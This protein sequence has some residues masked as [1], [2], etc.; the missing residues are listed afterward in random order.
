VAI[1]VKSILFCKLT[2]YESWSQIVMMFKMNILETLSSIC[3]IVPWQ[4]NFV[5]CVMMGAKSVSK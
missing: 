5:I 4:K 1:A 2:P 3:V